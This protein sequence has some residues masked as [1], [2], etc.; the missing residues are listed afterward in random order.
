MGK[1]I[2]AGGG[3]ENLK[4]ELQ[5]QDTLISDILETIVGKSNG[6]TAT[7]DTIIEGYSAY[8]G[9]ELVTGTYQPI[10]VPTL[11]GCSKYA[12]DKFTRDATAQANS[13]TLSHSLGQT[14]RFVF[15]YG[16]PQV[17]GVARYYLTNVCGVSNSG[18]V[19]YYSYS[20]VYG[21]GGRY[22][23]YVSTEEGVITES[24][25]KIPLAQVYQGNVEYTLVTMA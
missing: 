19:P 2:K 18:D 21:S 14:P 15:I 24:T 10:N 17:D 23:N 11:F 16:N 12:V 20:Y 13:V 5:T 7:A 1:G 6:A 25:I 8:V 3:A 9:Q 22:G 4:A